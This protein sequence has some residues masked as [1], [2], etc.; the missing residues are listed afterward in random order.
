MVAKVTGSKLYQS[1]WSLKMEQ[2]IRTINENGTQRW[3]LPNGELHRDEAAA[4][5]GADGTQMWY[6]HGKR[7]RDEAAARIWSDGTQMWYQHGKCHRIDGPAVIWAD[8]TKEYWLNDT[9]LTEGS[10]ALKLIKERERRK[11]TQDGT[12]D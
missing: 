2:P 5:I 7:H 10:L 8:G 9:E 3:R 1:S 11:E 12:T 6:Q 4:W